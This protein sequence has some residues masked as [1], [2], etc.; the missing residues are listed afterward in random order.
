M[1]EYGRC[2]P[3]NLRCLNEYSTHCVYQI[4]AAVFAF[5]NPA[6]RHHASNSCSNAWIA[7]NMDV[8]LCF[9]FWWYTKLW[10]STYLGVCLHVWRSCSKLTLMLTPHATP[11]RTPIT[12]PNHSTPPHSTQHLRPLLVSSP[13]VLRKTHLDQASSMNAP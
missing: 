12:H 11:L 1:C 6:M 13:Y 9:S 4:A 8:I 2:L 7:A 10:M 5:G 3:Y